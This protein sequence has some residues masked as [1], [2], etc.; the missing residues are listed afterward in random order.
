MK[1]WQNWRLAVPRVEFTASKYASALT[2]RKLQTLNKVVV[3]KQ[4]DS[5]VAKKTSGASRS[6]GKK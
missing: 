3:A 2:K 5:E 1:Q 4:K 6:S